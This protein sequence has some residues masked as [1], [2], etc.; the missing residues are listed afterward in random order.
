MMRSTD[1][2]T[3][4]DFRTALTRL[5]EVYPALKHMITGSRENLD[6]WF[7]SCEPYSLQE[8]NYGLHQ[9]RRQTV[10][11]P[12][13]ETVELALARAKRYFAQ[14]AER[15]EGLKQMEEQGGRDELEAFWGRFNV[16]MVT[17][18][19]C[20]PRVEYAME[21][22]RRYRMLGEHCPELKDMTE[23][24]A[25]EADVEAQ[26]LTERGAYVDH[27]AVA[28]MREMGILDGEFEAVLPEDG[29]TGKLWPPAPSEEETTA[30]T[31]L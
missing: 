14:E 30:T 31:E 28:Y 13:L 1:V 27:L 4:D 6:T 18:N 5:F 24:A 15:R 22:A 12:S 25:F 23:Q 2:M 3:R 8:F 29:E 16:K 7:K 26:R 20:A 10:T 19:I 21:R 9:L 17:D 11:T